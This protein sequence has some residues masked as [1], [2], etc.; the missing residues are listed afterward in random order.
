MGRIIVAAGPLTFARPSEDFARLRK[1]SED[2]AV[3]PFPHGTERNTNQEIQMTRRIGHVL[4]GA[5]MLAAVLVAT[6]W[7]ARSLWAGDEMEA[8]GGHDG[9]A[10]SKRSV[11][12]TWGFSSEVSYLMPPSAPTAT[13]NVA[14]GRVSFDGEGGCEVSNVVNVN[15][16]SQSFTSTSCTYSVKPDGFGEAEAVFPG[17][18][19]PSAPVAF[20][21]VDRGREL[22]FINTKYIVGA[23]TA[24]RQ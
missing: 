11:K 7:S 10:F 9:P 14:I 2:S 21:I 24:R 16:E 6:G 12:G 4:A 23:F 22:R 18:P 8:R 13:P 20:I 1:T 19:I 5:G 17:A 3:G 15:G